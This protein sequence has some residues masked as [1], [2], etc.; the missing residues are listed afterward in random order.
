MFKNIKSILKS[1]KG[2][3]VLAGSLAA[4]ALASGIFMGS[5][6]NMMQT[7]TAQ[8]ENVEVSVVSLTS[9]SEAK[10]LAEDLGVLDFIAKDENGDIIRFEAMQDKPI[11]IV[12]DENSMWAMIDSVKDGIRLAI[13]QY[14]ELFA[15]INP[16]YSFR[17]ISKEEYEKNPTSDPFIFITTLLKINTT[18]GYAYAVT[19]PAES[20][21]SVY[22]NGPIDSSSTIV[23]SSTATVHLT[24]EQIANIVAHEMS[25]ALGFEKH[26]ENKDS[27][28][29]KSSTGAAISSNY[30]SEDLLNTI[31]ACYYNPKTNVIPYSEIKDYLNKQASNR[32]KELE[33]YYKNNKDLIVGETQ[34][35]TIEKYRDNI[36]TFALQ[37]NL[38]AGNIDYII[39]SSYSKTNLYGQNITFYFNEDGTYVLEVSDDKRNIKCTGH[40]EIVDNTAVLKGEYYK[41][42]DMKYVAVKDTI[43]F[44]VFDNG[45]SAYATES[46]NLTILSV[47]NKVLENEHLL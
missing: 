27:I 28:M 47:L 23:I 20:A 18:N 36:R 22:G 35:E 44:S 9:N 43:Y 31:L 32:N 30:F 21:E 38:K 26:S 12:V 4:L 25:H 33:E 2:V 5:Q 34:K 3:S 37:N 40:Y 7:N 1:K 42:E 41:V 8:T 15:Y 19:S 24:V 17:Y 46:N 11:D 16:E 45:D 29:Y 10:A 6:S 39:G 14:N 13:D